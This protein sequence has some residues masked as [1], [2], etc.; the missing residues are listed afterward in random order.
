MFFRI[1]TATGGYRA[2]IVGGNGELM[3]WTEIYTTKASAQHAIDVVKAGAATAEVK[4][5]T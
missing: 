1:V 5:E 2:Q 4:D 3:F